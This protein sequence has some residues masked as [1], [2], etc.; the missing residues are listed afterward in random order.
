[1]SV[2]TTG[3]LVD[4]VVKLDEAIDMPNNSRVRVVVEA[5]DEQR[6]D[7]QAALESLLSR[8]FDSGGIRFSRDELYD[9]N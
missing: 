1:M 4:G 2:T 6:R 9:R 7:Q 3:V 8:S 5:V